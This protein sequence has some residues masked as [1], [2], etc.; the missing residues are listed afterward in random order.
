MKIP[1]WRWWVLI[2]FV[3]FFPVVLKPWWLAVVS[4]AIFV[5]LATFLR[6]KS[7]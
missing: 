5:L 2:I 1:A 6:P 4:V 3:V 7:E